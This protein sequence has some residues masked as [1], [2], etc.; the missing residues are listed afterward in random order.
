M[1]SDLVR[2]AYAGKE[3][4]LYYNDGTHALP[5]WIEIPRARNITVNRDRNLAEAELHGADDI[6]SVPGYRGFS[7]SFQYVRR[8]GNDTVFADLQTA[9][10]NGA[11]IELMHLNDKRTVV[12]ARGWKAPVLLG[13]FDF[14]DSGNDPS[15]VTINFALADAY[16]STDD[17]LGVEAEE[18]T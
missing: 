9:Q 16:D 15:V 5:D 11:I 8:R 1:A 13:A 14:S 18:I 12:G 7:G 17:K 10:T 6:G 3:T 4:H 2:G